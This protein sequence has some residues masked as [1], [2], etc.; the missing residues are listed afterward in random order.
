VR[1]SA[2]LVAPT[3]PLKQE[4]DHPKPADRRCENE[5][6]TRVAPSDKGD[7]K[8]RKSY[9]RWVCERCWRYELR[10]REEPMFCMI[11]PDGKVVINGD[12]VVARK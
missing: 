6:C 1:G 3:V 12:G 5:N 4:P 8:L 9:G 7:Y 10:K 11:G 2:Q